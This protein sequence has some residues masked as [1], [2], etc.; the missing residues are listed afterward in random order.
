M[1]CNLCCFSW[2][3]ALPLYGFNYS[4]GTQIAWAGL[5]GMML[6]VDAC[7]Q[8]VQEIKVMPSES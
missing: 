7:R 8:V 6:P 5:L 2:Q 4:A 3:S 1:K